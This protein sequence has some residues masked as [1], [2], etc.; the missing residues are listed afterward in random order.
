M[1]NELKAIG[2][3]I[4][5]VKGWALAYGMTT[6]EYDAV[7]AT[8]AFNK[9][10][11]TLSEVEKKCDKCGK[12]IEDYNTSDNT[13]DLPSV[14]YNLCTDCVLEVTSYIDNNRGNNE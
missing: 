4:K 14:T 3:F 2:N 10:K 6:I 7:K 13:A 9:L 8:D 11:A 12:V 1:D 5:S